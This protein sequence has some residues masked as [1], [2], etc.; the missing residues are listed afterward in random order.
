MRAI[1]IG[2]VRYRIVCAERDGQWFAHAVRED[3][4][5]VFGIERA[6][7]SEAHAADRLI[8]WLT[9]QSEHAAAL[10]A[11]QQAERGY[12]RAIAGSAFAHPSEGPTAN[13]IQKE[14]LEAVEAARLRLD[15]VRARKPE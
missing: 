7:A 15:D 2:S 3:T 6:G 9:W 13:E 1:A 11:L 8:G 5:D 10:E 12:H 4:G 14:S